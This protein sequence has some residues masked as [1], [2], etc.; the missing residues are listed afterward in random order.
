MR[1]F[2]TTG[3]TVLAGASTNT[4]PGVLGSPTR[5]AHFS[6]LR[7]NHPERTKSAHEVTTYGPDTMS[8]A[9]IRLQRHNYGPV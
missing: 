4:E 1:G 2:A 6:K 7:D 3:R 8:Q 5:L 9:L